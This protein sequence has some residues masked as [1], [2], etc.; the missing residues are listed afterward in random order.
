M[1]QLICVESP[2]VCLRLFSLVFGAVS[3]VEMCVT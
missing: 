1:L 3:S 2:I